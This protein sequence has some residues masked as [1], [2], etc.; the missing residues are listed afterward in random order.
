MNEQAAAP[1]EGKPTIMAVTAKVKCS[2]KRP[3]WSHDGAYILDFAPD[4]GDGRN[5][6]WAEAT[7]ALSLNMTVKGDVADAFEPGEAYT[8]TFESETREG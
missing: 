2:N 5:A 3:V 8:L 7:P 6:E 1:R 4:Y